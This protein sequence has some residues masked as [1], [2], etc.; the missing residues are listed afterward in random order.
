[1]DFGPI[2]PSLVISVPPIGAENILFL[3]V[4]PPIV[5]GLVRFGKLR[6]IVLLSPFA[7]I[8]VLSDLEENL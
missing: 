6:F 3:Y 8:V 7:E 4:T 2:H 5:I 1:V